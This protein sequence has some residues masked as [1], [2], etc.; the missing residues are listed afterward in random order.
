MVRGLLV[1]F[2]LLDGHLVLKLAVRVVDA[3]RMGLG[4]NGGHVVPSGVGLLDVFRSAIAEDLR[5]RNARGVRSG[6][7]LVFY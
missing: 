3:V 2:D 5:V 1:G 6:R 7:L 4:C